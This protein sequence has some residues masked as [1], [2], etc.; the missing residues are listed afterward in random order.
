MKIILH[1]T[2]LFII[3]FNLYA[4]KSQT[5]TLHNE[6][7]NDFRGSGISINFKA[8]NRNS[9]PIIYGGFS[10]NTLK[11]D[12]AL[13]TNDRNQIYPFYGFIGS[14][15]NYPISPFIELGLDIGDAILD[16]SS[17]GEILEVDIYYTAGIT[18]TFDK[19]FDISLYHKTYNLYFTEIT[20]T[21]RQDVHINITGISVSFYL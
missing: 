19:A 5:I 20:D 13:E 3:S 14:S 12:I 6:I 18:I 2:L 17:D 4:D 7:D 8:Y 10:L 21:T 9:L 15:L 16:K 1:I 11:S